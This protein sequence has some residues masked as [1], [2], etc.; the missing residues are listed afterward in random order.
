MTAITSL[1]VTSLLAI[2]LPAGP[3]TPVPATPAVPPPTGPVPTSPATPTPSS[4]APTSPTTP[5]PTKPAPTGPATPT[6]AKPTPTS[7]ATSAPGRPAVPLATGLAAAA[8]P[9][10]WTTA[11]SVATGDQ[12]VPAIAANRNGRV[13]VVWEDD[14][15]TT[16]PEDDTHS[17]IYLRVFNNGTPVYELKLSAGGTAGTAWRHVTPDVG[18]DDRGNAVVVW[19]DDPD[20]NGFYNV[21]YRVVSPTGTVLASGRAN[22]SADGQQL[23]PKVSVD[24]D[25]VPNSATAVGFTVV[26]EDIQGT[27]PATIRAAGYTGNTT[28]A[29]E[30]L[31]S[32][33]TGTHHRPDVAVSAS[34]DAV[35]VWDEDADANASF[36]IG[37]ARFARSNG[38]VNL[39][40]RVANSASGGQQRRPAV[41]AN[42]NGDFGVAWESDHTGTPGVWSRSF[43]STGTAR[44]D[45]V[46]ASSG[47][48]AVAPTV[49]IDDQANTVVGWTVQTASQ[50]IAARGFNPDGTGTGR[51]PAGVL[52]QT[53]AGRQEQ[54]ALTSS[55]WGEISVCYTDD[56]DG[57][58]FDQIILGVDGSNSGW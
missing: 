41:A 18:L 43:S 8:V 46:E 20:G 28:K 36:N 32:Q 40:R 54:I 3:A 26:W 44:H 7:P 10:T 14:R 53:T 29:Y 11:N 38:A 47:T 57:N 6:P 5:T 23:W 22:A 45:D 19:A 31:V 12:D 13:A 48:G 50:D 42:F 51:L 15:D 16:A 37:L 1:L 17:E 21:P 34:G 39:S 35:V 49:G 56:N 27:L 30:V 24:P 55:P 9:V 52:G 4:P 58:L 25:G 2:S 33:A